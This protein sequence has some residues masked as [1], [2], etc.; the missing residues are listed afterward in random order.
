MLLKR[1]V[2]DAKLK[3][4]MTGKRHYVIPIFNEYIVVNSQITKKMK[5]KNGKRWSAVE[6]SEAAVYITPNSTFHNI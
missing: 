2:K 4:V 6:L 1:A 3:W 5:R